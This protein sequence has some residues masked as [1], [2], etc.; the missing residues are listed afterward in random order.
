MPGGIPSYRNLELRFE[1]QADGAYQVF[2]FAPDGSTGRGTFAP[3]LSDEELDDFV[4]G[5]GLVR[6]TR[7]ARPERMERAKDVGGRLFDAVMQEQV[8]EVF[9]SAG[10]AA[11]AEGDALRITLCL[12]GAPELM[13]LPWEFL[14]RR[15]SFLAQSIRTPVVRSLDLDRARQPRRVELPLRILAVVSQPD[16]LRRAGLRRGAREAD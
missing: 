11:K 3:P 7:G 1:R 14:Y 9:H 15:P 13:R 10:A 2:A 8:G 4:C 16:G 6:R 12:S 5:V